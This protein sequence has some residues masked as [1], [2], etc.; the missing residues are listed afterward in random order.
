MDCNTIDKIDRL[1]IPGMDTRLGIRWQI[2]L[3]VYCVTSHRSRKVDHTN[4]DSVIAGNSVGMLTGDLTCTGTG[5][6]HCHIFDR[7]ITPVDS[8][9]V[10]FGIIRV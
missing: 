10:I 3:Y 6:Y 7:S 2:H 8:S 5:H 9:G 1:I 4:F